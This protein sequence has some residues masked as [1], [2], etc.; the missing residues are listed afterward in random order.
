MEVD[1]IRV[2]CTSVPIPESY[3]R[4]PQLHFKNKKFFVKGKG[5]NEAILIIGV[6]N[7]YGDEYNPHLSTE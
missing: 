2:D 5:V 6:S 3:L 1:E 7:L 4:Q